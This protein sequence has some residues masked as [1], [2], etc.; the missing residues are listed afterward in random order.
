MRLR[1]AQ[2]IVPKEAVADGCLPA[3]DEQL[4]ELNGCQGFLVESAES[5][6]DV[7]VRR[8]RDP[9]ADATRWDSKDLELFE[10]LALRS[11]SEAQSLR[12]LLGRAE[13]EKPTAEAGRET[14]DVRG[15]A[16]C[17]ATSHRPLP[18]RYLST[19]SDRGAITI[20]RFS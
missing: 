14:P 17:G 19:D 3:E 20:G 6:E 1:R 10:D 9:R 8:F 7:V 4:V 16:E 12:S 11:H 5:S 13:S 18:M 15:R 2:P